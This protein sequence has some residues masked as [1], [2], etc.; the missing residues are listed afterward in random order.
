MKQEPRQANIVT[1][2]SIAEAAALDQLG[3][4]GGMGAMDD[5]YKELA[6]W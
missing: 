5:I 6:R 4:M 1:P 2:A 3:S